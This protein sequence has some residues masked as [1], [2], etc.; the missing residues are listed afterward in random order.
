MA[1]SD[2]HCHLGFVA[3]PYKLAR[4][5]RQA[6]ACLFTVG[7]QPSEYVDIKTNVGSFENVAV[8]LGLHPW[9]VPANEEE[10]I[11]VLRHFDALIDPVQQCNPASCAQVK[12]AC[13]KGCAVFGACD[14]LPEAVTSGVAGEAALESTSE[15]TSVSAAQIVSEATTSSTMQN[16]VRFIGEVGLDFSP[17]WEETRDLQLFALRHIF[18][19]IEGGESKVIS[20]HCVKAYDEMLDLLEQRSIPQKHTCI[21]HWFSGPSEHL[22]KAIEL[23]CYFSV[24][25][26]MLASKRGKEYAKAIPA[27]RLLLE[28]DEPFVFL[29]K[30]PSAYSGEIIGP[31]E[32]EFHELEKSLQESA[33]ILV[34]L[35]GSSVLE[36]L[37]HTS[38]R[39]FS[40]GG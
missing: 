21:F 13:A 20:L 8:G 10:L 28:T 32:Y 14:A 17:R 36:E 25:K 34:E 22:Q 24:G 5:A 16:A 37:S 11:A 15:K 35:K 12:A 31:V 33:Q 1:F 7:V 30:K 3:D 39:L 4:D 18:S 6:N 19:V 40:C 29:D 26:R 38:R 23:G 9:W 27:Q 2:F